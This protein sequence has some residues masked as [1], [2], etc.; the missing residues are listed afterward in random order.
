MG[1]LIL[2]PA[3]EF[4]QVAVQIVNLK[5]D[6]EDAQDALGEDQKFTGLPIQII[7]INNFN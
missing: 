6:L 2:V 7:I 4:V 3:T 1:G 5:N